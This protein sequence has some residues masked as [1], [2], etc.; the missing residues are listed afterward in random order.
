MSDA[1]E[2]EREKEKEGTPKKAVFHSRRRRRRHADSYR[3][4]PGLFLPLSLSSFAYKRD[5]SASKRDLLAVGQMTHLA[6]RAG[7]KSNDNVTLHTE[8]NWSGSFPATR[9]R[10]IRGR[11]GPKGP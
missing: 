7:T 8:R 1:K 6:V 5:E 10:Q 4:G 11:I 9:R 3:R 2:R